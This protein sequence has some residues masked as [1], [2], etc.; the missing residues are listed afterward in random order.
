[1]TKCKCGLKTENYI[2]RGN[3][4]PPVSLECDSKCNDA[5]TEKKKATAAAAAAVKDEDDADL[6]DDGGGDGGGDGKGDIR[7][8]G[9]GKKRRQQRR[10]EREAAAA[11]AEAAR[12][13]KD[14]N[15]AVKAAVAVIAG[16]A[17]V[18]VLQMI[19]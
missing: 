4:R 6:D 5:A 9:E 14:P 19:L 8:R 1:M 18:W 7:N 13:V 16:L 2:C 12:K 10:A 17:V 15:V 11:A 3:R